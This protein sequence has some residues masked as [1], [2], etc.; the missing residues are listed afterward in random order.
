LLEPFVKDNPSAFRAKLLLAAEDVQQEKYD[1][2]LTMASQV[3]EKLPNDYYAQHVIGLALLGLN[4]VDEAEMRL[5]RAS[6]LKPDFSEAHYQLGLLYARK[7]ET[8]QK[9]DASFRRALALGHAKPEIYKNLASIA[10]KNGRYPEAIQQLQSAIASNPKYADAYFLLA[11]AL[12]KSGKTQEAADA[13]RRFQELNAAVAD[14]RARSNKSQAAYEEG[15]S[16]LFAKDRTFQ[17]VNF[18]RAYDAFTRAAAELPELDAAYYRLAQIDFLRKD[19]SRGTDHIRQALKF[20]PFEP[21]YYFVLAS[22][23][24][25]SDLRGAVDAAAKAVSLKPGVA[26]FYNLLGKLLEKAGDYPHAVQSYRRASEL[27]PADPVF[28][29][30]LAAAQKKLP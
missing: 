20:N 19:I 8:L 16:L 6:T 7:P 10:I 3:S 25:N 5:K 17:P 22:C 12:R 18:A 15:M 29:N 23:L 26:D 1:V 30:N 14:K 21:E 11:D 27:E 4:R 2:A 13:A 24:E 9:A 28:R